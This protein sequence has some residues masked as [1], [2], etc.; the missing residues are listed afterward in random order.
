M[1][2]DTAVSDYPKVKYAVYF[3]GRNNQPKKTQNEV[4]TTFLSVLQFA[5]KP[6]TFE[7]FILSLIVPVLSAF[8][9]QW[10]PYHVLIIKFEFNRVKHSNQQRNTPE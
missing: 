1:L 10:S 2:V 9:G 3:G 6:E 4:F 7:P 8:V 5:V